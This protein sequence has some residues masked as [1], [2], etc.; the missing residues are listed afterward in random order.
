MYKSEIK[1]VKKVKSKMRNPW[2]TNHPNT[3]LQSFT[4]YLRQIP[5]ERFD[6]CL[7]EDFY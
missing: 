2:N 1:N 7:L 4:K 6:F 3:K 5:R